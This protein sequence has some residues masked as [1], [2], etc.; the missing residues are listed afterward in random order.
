MGGLL[1]VFR[2]SR[3]LQ[4]A[5]PITI[6]LVAAIVAV[7]IFVPGDS[8]DA[9]VTLEENQELVA[10]RYGT[11]AREIPVEGR[12]SFP[13][14]E[15][16]T[17]DA[18]GVVGDI[19]VKEGQRIRKGE[20]LATFDPLAIAQ[21]ERTSA[22]ERFNVENAGGRLEALMIPRPVSISLAETN[23]ADAAIAVDDAENALND[24]LRPV[25]LKLALAEQ[26]FAVAQRNFDDGKETLEDLLEPKEIDVS[27][28][29]KRVAS[30]KVE[31]DD[32]QEAFDDIKEG[33][34]PEEDVRDYQNAVDFAK[35]NLNNAQKDLEDAHLLWENSVRLAGNSFDRSLEQYLDVYR[36][37]LGIELT[38]AELMEDQDVLFETWGIDLE[39]LF[40]RFGNTLYATARPVPDASE[41]R[42]NETTIWAWLNLHPGYTSV[43]GTCDEGEI[44]GRSQRCIEREFEDAF[45]VYD[46]I[47]DNF[48]TVK[49]NASK[50]IASS[51]DAVTAAEDTLADAQDDLNDVIDGPDASEIEDAEKRLDVANA[52]L[53]EAEEDLTELVADIDPV[54]IAK[55]E[56]DV[57][58]A[59]AALDEA[60][61]DLERA[62]DKSLDIQQARKQFQLAQANHEQAK[63]QFDNAGDLHRRDIELAE[64][65][66]NLSQAAFNDVMEDLDGSVIISPFDGVVSLINVE[67]D[68]E[69]NDESR[70]VEVTD[71][72]VAEVV[73][74][75]DAA[76]REFIR[77]GSPATVTIQAL[78]GRSF[79]G[80]VT[81]IAPEPKTERGVIS[82]PVIISVNIPRGTQVPIE[83]TGVTTVILG[84]ESGVIMAPDDS[85]A[86]DS[87]TEKPFVNVMRDGAVFE[88]PV[89]VGE[90]Y[91]GWK[92]VYAGLLQGDQVV[93]NSET[94]TPLPVG[95]DSTGNIRMP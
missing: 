70:V 37:W 26:A 41:T 8:A 68:D 28:A 29:E 88:Q 50:V 82:F 52:N 78:Q 92:V 25:N 86:S 34:F 23:L 90:S 84:E 46:E 95:T 7:A 11:F 80:T 72:S 74:V 87:V 17:F 48:T 21:L 55:A 39:P 38:E 83:L 27:S 49:D 67:I 81:S 94:L 71:P 79:R 5:L 54:D 45:D 44:L 66:V 40:E 77:I 16:L 42:L 65:D 10:V 60:D 3:Q 13:I 24:V 2:K 93:V 15:S 30:A 63:V 76:N 85:F 57:A 19:L 58:V 35:T 1:Q 61:E 56:A 51:K 32:A 69:V 47:R 62:R 9:T 53:K 22:V 14:R 36:F 4:I 89:I 12:L 43:Q 59:K 64:A 31:V 75:I 33:S 6:L 18:T 73:G 20:V 91:D